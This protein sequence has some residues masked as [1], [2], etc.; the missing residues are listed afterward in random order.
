MNTK[1]GWWILIGLTLLIAV[2]AIVL[3]VIPTPVSAPTIP[4]NTSEPTRPTTGSINTPNPVPTLHSKIVVT[5]PKSG[6]TV[7][8]TFVVSGNAPGTWFFEASFPVQVRDKDNN[9]I[10]QAIAQAQGDWMTTGLVTFTASITVSNYTG[11]ATVV[12]L[13]N[14]PSG[15]PEHD[16]ALEVPITIQ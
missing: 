12:L 16:D 1:V 2:M 6:A 14:N 13:R 10:G 9:K 4:T 8:N 7:G 5:S 15:L 3:F 11:P